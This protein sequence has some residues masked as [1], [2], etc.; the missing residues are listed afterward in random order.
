MSSASLGGMFI[1]HLPAGY[2][3]GRAILSAGPSAARAR[4]ALLLGTSLVAS[5]FPDLDLAWFYWVDDRQHLHHTYWT[6]IPSFWLVSG[7]AATALAVLCRARRAVAYIGVFVLGALVHLVLDTVAGGIH[8]YAPWSTEE[9]RWIE[10]P[11]VH[12]WWIANFILHWSFGIELAF[13][14]A[15]IVVRA[16][17]LGR[18]RQR[19]CSH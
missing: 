16:R 5:V 7:L 9:V 12:D 10:V 14:L 19:R 4:P 18:G 13:V 15:A 6:H 11:A 3:V 1:A 17:G 8:W 2:L